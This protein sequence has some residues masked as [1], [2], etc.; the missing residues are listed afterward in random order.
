MVRLKGI[1]VGIALRM[2]VHICAQLCRLFANWWTGACKAPL[3]MEFPRQEYW[4][5]LPLP[6]PR[7]LTD[8][9]MEFTSLAL[10]EDS[11]PLCHLGFNSV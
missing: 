1:N 8:P 3:S 11:L 4:S 2:C 7:D 9:G 6:T 5:R 10:V